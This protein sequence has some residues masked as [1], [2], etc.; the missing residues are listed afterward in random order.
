MSN[1]KDGFTATRVGNDLGR[2]SRCGYEGYLTKYLIFNMKALPD[3]QKGWRSFWDYK[4][5]KV[6]PKRAMVLFN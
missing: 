4:I 2:N 3:M 6:P 1:W 5:R